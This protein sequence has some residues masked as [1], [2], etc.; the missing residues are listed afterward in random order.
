MHKIPDIAFDAAWLTGPGLSRE[1]GRALVTLL[2]ELDRSSS[3][4]EAARASGV[5]YRFAWGVLSDAA[6]AFGAPLVEMQRGRS[7]RL[8]SLGRRVVL[9]DARVRQ[10]LAEP[11]ERLLSEIPLILAD[12][13]SSAGHRLS[14]HASHDLAIAALPKLCAPGLQLDIAFRGS[15]DCLATLARGECDL[16]G[17]HVPDAL[18]RAAAAAASLG[19]WLDSRKH[20]LVHFVRREQGLIVRPGSRIRNVHDLARPGVR[21][22]HRQ[23][24]PAESASRELSVAAAVARGRADAGFGLRAEAARHKLAFVPL[25]VERY[26]IAC[27][28]SSLQGPALS[29]FTGKLRSAELAATVGKLP[30]YSADQAGELHPLDTALTW[31]EEER[32]HPGA[33]HP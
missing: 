26:F 7:A 6:S 27:A 2:R 14:L 22:I 20:V 21:F 24:P 17:F 33:T 31:V 25:A 28:K 32:R 3:L 11:F 15:D 9:A 23:T 5:S 30:G 19:K 8:S 10:A 18:P 12:T 29:A 13:L 4:G 16:A 1:R